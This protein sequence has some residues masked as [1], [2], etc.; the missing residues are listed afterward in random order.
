MLELVKPLRW[1]WGIVLVAFLAVVFTVIVFTLTAK[2]QYEAAATLHIR[3]GGDYQDRLFEYPSFY[4]QKYFLKNQIAVLES[5]SLG[6]EV[7]DRLRESIH[8]DSLA[9]LGNEPRNQERALRMR[10]KTQ[11]KNRTHDETLSK[12]NIAYRLSRLKKIS[13]NEGSDII[14]LKIRSPQSWEAAFILNT[15]V[16]VF[17]DYDMAQNR[18]EIRE[19]KRFLEEKLSDVREQL[20]SSQSRLTS[21]KKT[22]GV[23]SLSDETEQLVKQLTS[24][25]SLYKKTKTD[26]EAVENKLAHLKDQLS[27]SEKTFVEDMTRVNKPMLQEMQKQMAD[28][29]ARRAYIEAQLLSA[30]LPTE[31]NNQL[32]T[33]ESNINGLKEEILK[34]TTKL[35]ESHL[36]GINPLVRSENLIT[37]IFESETS[38]E[39]LSAKTQEL[40]R[41]VDEYKGK[42]GRLP[43]K[44]RELADLE[45]EVQV[46]SKIYIMLREK[47]EEAR[48]T[49]AGLVG[50]IR[51]VDWAEPS[52]VPVSPKPLRNLMLGC[53]LGLLLG[54]GLAFSREAFRNS[55]QERTDLDGL[56]LQFIG[57]V[58]L[59]KRV[60]VH[61][62]AKRNTKRDWSLNRAREIFP[63]L[64]THYNGHAGISEA[65]RSIRTAIH[66]S[67]KTKPLK[68][69]L[70]TSPGPAEGKSTTAANLAVSMAQ[71][72]VKTLLVDSDLR[73][74]VLDILFIGSHRKV[75][76]TN[77]LGRQIDWKE[78]VRETTEKNLYILSAGSA[79]KNS[80]EL[81]STNRMRAFVNEAK[82]RFGTV[83]FDSPPLLPVT[84]ALVLSALLDGVVLVVRVEKTTKTSLE[85]SVKLLR[86][87]RANILG[88]VLTGIHLEDWY[89]NRKHYKDYIEMQNEV[90][91]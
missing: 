90:N 45:M 87:A 17:K 69:I 27:E 9:I 70:L 68:T 61:H 44:S 62:P 2:P 33:L 11:S 1:N 28:L 65:F 88:T 15:W 64:L 63:Y 10:V 59:A 19:T 50:N 13:L 54:I 32:M 39:E 58:P 81:L 76:L 36:S 51:V 37:Q 89:G 18:S 26:L 48:I 12:Q 80:P 78:A 77:H 85:Q 67:S 82:E 4:T 53:F 6:F 22:E 71:R 16:E 72:G 34:E 20:D 29:V 21:F 7:V 49:E 3:E 86:S 83:I 14:E 30:G 55:I 91:A 66:L 52:S 23:V 40:E 75:G 43:D 8:A 47:Y 42:M 41:I 46:N 57:S 84:D 73:K 35:V 79:V 25:E 56:G 74:P 31:G 60:R 5:R 38:R 24:F